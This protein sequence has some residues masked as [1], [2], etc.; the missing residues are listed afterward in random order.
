MRFHRV[1][2]SSAL[3]FSGPVCTPKRTSGMAGPGRVIPK[4]SLV[5]VLSAAPHR[6]NAGTS[7]LG[8][9]PVQLQ[10]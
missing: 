2:M 1:T 6:A 3:T 7:W 10:R 4:N 5:S 9:P 8:S